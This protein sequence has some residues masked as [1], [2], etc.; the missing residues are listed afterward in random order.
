MKTFNITITSKNKNS[1]N[2]F[3]SILKTNKC[4]DLKKYFQK[5]TKHKRMSILKSPHVNKTAQEQFE[6]IIFNKQFTLQTIKNLKF[7][8]FLKRL[9]FELFPDINFKL[10]YKINYHD[11]RKI[12]L[13]IF[14]PNNFKFKKYKNSKFFNLNLDEIKLLKRAKK[15]T[16]LKKTNIL[17][18]LFDF[19]GEFFKKI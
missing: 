6:K 3:F 15:E 8:I 4:N 1:I 7:Y 14:N 13:K 5:K 10:K 12:K 19:Y 2:N 9:N 16:F 18:N 17:L 11:F